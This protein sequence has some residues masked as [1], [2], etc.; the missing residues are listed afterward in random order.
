MVLGYVTKVDHAFTDGRLTRTVTI[1]GWTEVSSP[2]MKAL[3]Y[4]LQMSS[5]FVSC[6]R[7]ESVARWRRA[8]SGQ[9]RL[10][11]ADGDGE[12][13][14]AIDEERDG[15]VAPSPFPSSASQNADS[16]VPEIP[17]VVRRI[18]AFAQALG[19][20]VDGLVALLE[21]YD[22]HILGGSAPRQIDRSGVA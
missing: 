20:T 18:Y 15:V 3:H 5:T 13:V 17:D 22:L 10:P 11:F 19:L 9:N 2:S 12:W 14:E 21:S 1:N 6:S 16:V 7:R 8:V 4:V